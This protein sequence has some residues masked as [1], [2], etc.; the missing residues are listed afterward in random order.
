MSLIYTCGVD[1]RFCSGSAA[2]G[3]SGLRHIRTHSSSEEAFRC[4]ARHLVNDE[5]YERTG[6]RT[7]APS[8]GG[9][10]LVLD[11]K[12]KFGGV[13]RKGK[14][15][16]DTASSASRVMSKKRTGGFIL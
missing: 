7:F 14:R 3:S 12:S 9:P 5:G 11:K 10:I 4:M 1:K 15:G 2:S 6:S 13:L 16:T 8:D